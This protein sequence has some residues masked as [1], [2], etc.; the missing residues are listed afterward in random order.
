[1]VSGGTAIAHDLSISILHGLKIEQQRAC[2]IYKFPTLL[3]G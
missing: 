3:C 1:V 2:M